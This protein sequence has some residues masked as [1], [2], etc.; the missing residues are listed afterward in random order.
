MDRDLILLIGLCFLP[1]AFVALVSAWA[2]RRRPWAALILGVM[3]GGMAGW[4]QFTHPQG[5]YAL[6]DLPTIALETLARLMN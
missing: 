2:D 4:A 1:L 3:G 5:G 6:E